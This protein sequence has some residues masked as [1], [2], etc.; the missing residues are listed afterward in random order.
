MLGLKNEQGDNNALQEETYGKVV[1]H[2]AW[3]LCQGK[4][5]KDF[6]T[7]DR[8]RDKLSVTGGVRGEWYQR[9]GYMETG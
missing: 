8:I 2:G 6:V 3:T 9:Q 7:S 1:G 4:G 5:R